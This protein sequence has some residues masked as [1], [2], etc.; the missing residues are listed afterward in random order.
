M[1][2]RHPV[3]VWTTS[4]HEVSFSVT[5]ELDSSGDQT[6]ALTGDTGFVDSITHSGVG[7]YQ[8]DLADKWYAGCSQLVVEIIKETSPDAIPFSRGTPSTDTYD[9]TPVLKFGF[10]DTTGSLKDPTDCFLKVSGKLRQQA[11][12]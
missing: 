3:S 4:G 2:A 12:S 6:G 8:L 7:L 5:A 10:I 1:A 9:A 11:G